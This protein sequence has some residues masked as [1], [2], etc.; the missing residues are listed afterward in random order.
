[1]A[2]YDLAKSFY[3]S[4]PFGARSGYNH[5]FYLK[6]TYF[7]Q[8]IF[9][10][11]LSETKIYFTQK[12]D[13]HPSGAQPVLMHIVEKYRHLST[14]W[15]LPTGNLVVEIFFLVTGCIATPYLNRP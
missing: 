1:M 10:D 3:V 15:Q 6:P 4:G 13:A 11:N 5:T 2:G 7:T 8:N 14:T 12:F 9:T